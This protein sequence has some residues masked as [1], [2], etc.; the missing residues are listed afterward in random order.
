IVNH[1]AE[2]IVVVNDQY[3]IETF[4]PAAEKLFG[5]SCQEIRG[6]SFDCLL[7]DFVLPL[8]DAS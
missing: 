5:F 7:P 2:G 4:N 3:G 6:K 1:A 8:P